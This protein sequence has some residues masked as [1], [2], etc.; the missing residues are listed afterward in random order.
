MKIINAK[1]GI[2]TG[3]PLLKETSGTIYKHDNK[4]K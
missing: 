2:I 3:I 1:G 4:R